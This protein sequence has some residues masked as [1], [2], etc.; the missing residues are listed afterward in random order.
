VNT[1]KR[2]RRFKNRTGLTYHQLAEIF[3]V[4]YE[5]VSAWLN[6][7]GGMQADCEATLTRLEGPN[8]QISPRVRPE[9]A[10]AFQMGALV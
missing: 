7:H 4:E 1:C 3:G 10:Q 2:F 8:P 6:G 9:T 5:T